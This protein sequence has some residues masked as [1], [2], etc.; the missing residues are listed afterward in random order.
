[1][2]VEILPNGG[3]FEI[4]L[5]GGRVGT[6]L[7]WDSSDARGGAVEETADGEMVGGMMMVNP[8][9]AKKGRVVGA[10]DVCGGRGCETQEPPGRDC[11]F[12]RLCLHFSAAPPPR[13][14]PSCLHRSRHNRKI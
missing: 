10:V 11:A 9:A 12:Q 3:R 7:C 13:R 2:G 14:R 6:V 5:N 8:D 4:L 1:M